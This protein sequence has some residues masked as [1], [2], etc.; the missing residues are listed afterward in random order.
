M[1]F[2]SWIQVEN[3]EKYHLNNVF[4]FFLVR[5]FPC[6]HRQITNVFICFLLLVSFLFKAFVRSFTIIIIFPFCFVILIFL[7]VVGYC[8]FKNGRKTRHP[9]QYTYTFDQI[10]SVM[11]SDRISA[12]LP[13]F[14][15]VCLFFLSSLVLFSMNKDNAIEVKRYLLKTKLSYRK[16]LKKISC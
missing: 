16:S 1:H 4:C 11:S 15:F 8:T 3:T 12:T 13:M 6:T 14:F 7:F 9:L 2:C 5:F 10:D